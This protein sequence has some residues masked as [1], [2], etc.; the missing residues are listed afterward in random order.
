MDGGSRNGADN[1][2]DDSSWRLIDKVT[3]K[4]LHIRLQVLLWKHGWPMR[5]ARPRKELGTLG[6]CRQRG[7]R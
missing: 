6:C 4:K 5:A 3:L 7:P 2:S 1:F